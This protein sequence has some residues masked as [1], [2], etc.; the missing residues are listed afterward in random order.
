MHRT[1]GVNGGTKPSTAKTSPN[2]TVVVFDN[3]KFK[4]LSATAQ[5][6]FCS[7]QRTRTQASMARVFI[8]MTSHFFAGKHSTKITHLSLPLLCTRKHYKASQRQR[9]RKRDRQR[10]T[11]TNSTTKHT[12]IVLLDIS[13]FESSLYGI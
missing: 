10:D 4:F 8:S 12:V 6:R 5:R 9:E 2:G 3:S 13:G 7:S 1:K 11:R